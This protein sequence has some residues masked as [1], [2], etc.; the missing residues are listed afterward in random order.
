M[1]M[2]HLNF[3][4]RCIIHLDQTLK[5]VLGPAISHRPYP[6]GDEPVMTLPASD[7]K[8]S[9]RLMRVN[10]AGEISAQALYRAQALTA[11]QTANR[12]A[13]QH[14]AEEENDHL[15]WCHQ[16]LQELHSHPSYLNPVWYGGS[17][18]IGLLAGLLGD[19]WNLGFVAETEKQVVMHL[20]HHLEKVSK[21]D[22]KTIKILLKM[23]EEELG[24]ATVAQT[25]GAAELPEFIKV[26]MRIC[27]KVMTTTAAYV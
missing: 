11:R 9:A 16:R 1:F 27:S 23:Q 20:S 21:Q 4:D 22:I 3:L 14:A 18:L 12:K 13:L 24:H 17:F 2:R 5:T 10:H 25:A 15:A 19:P 8:L 6:A 7:R 26:I